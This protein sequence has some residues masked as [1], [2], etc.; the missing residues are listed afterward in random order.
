MREKDTIVYDF[1]AGR[2]SARERNRFV[3]LMR[4]SKDVRELSDWHE[5]VYKQIE[6]LNPEELQQLLQLLEQE[7]KS[8]LVV[9]FWK[10][11]LKYAAIFIGLLG[12]YLI[13]T[14]YQEVNIE[15]QSQQALAS[16]QT[17]DLADG[18]AVDLEKNSYIETIRFD[19]EIREVTLI[20][21]A[22]FR[23]KP[24]QKPFVVHTP[25]GYTTRVL[26]T[27][28]KIQSQHNLYQV[29]VDKGRVAI[30]HGGS[31]IGMLQKGDFLKVEDGK[32]NLRSS[33]VPLTFDNKPLSEVVQVVN[34]VY[35]T[36]IRLDASINDQIKCKV[37]FD[38]QLTILDIIEVLCEIHNFSYQIQDDQVSI[39]SK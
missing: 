12:G 37:S 4:Y 3:K 6:V 9:S 8:T 28:F 29:T 17:I 33:V 26:G 34:D 14:H 24:G 18:S 30:D 11:Y 19:D 35:D 21:T 36:N 13:Y 25:D 20:G 2:L 10:P 39:K 38:T 23:V 1:L 7:Q 31:N 16:L 22:S 27:E 5:A 32:T 15:T